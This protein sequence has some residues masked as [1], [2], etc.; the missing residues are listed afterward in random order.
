MAAIKKIP[1]VGF[2]IADLRGYS[3]EM[4]VQMI[5]DEL[6]RRKEK[7]KDNHLCFYLSD[8]PRTDIST[9]TTGDLAKILEKELNKKL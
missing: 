4:Q 5:G 3:V 9:R 1:C 2:F 7:P 6:D 8:L